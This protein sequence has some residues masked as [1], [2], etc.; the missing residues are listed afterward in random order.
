MSQENVEIVREWL[1][2]GQGFRALCLA[3]PCARRRAD[4]RNRRAFT[5]ASGHEG[6]RA[7][8][9]D[10]SGITGDVESPA[11]DT[12]IHPVLRPESRFFGSAGWTL[13]VRSLSSTAIRIVELSDRRSTSAYR[14]SSLSRECG[15]HTWATL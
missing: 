1:G 4:Q 12:D 7:W 10:V 3:S 11:H 15:S 6:F 13:A 9:A 2:S 14:R 5:N 8:R